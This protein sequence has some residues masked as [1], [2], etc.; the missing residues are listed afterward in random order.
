MTGFEERLR[1]LTP[2]G[3]LSGLPVEA[4]QEAVSA[5]VEAATA[6]DVCDMA[7]AAHSRPPPAWEDGFRKRLADASAQAAPPA[8]RQLAVLAGAALVE[9]FGD[10]SRG[11]LAILCSVGARHAG[12]APALP[13][14]AVTPQQMRE[15][16]AASRQA[17]APR[18]P[19]ITVP[20]SAYAAKMPASGAA[21]TGDALQA[22]LTAFADGVADALGRGHLALV[23]AA[24]K[25]EAALHEQ[26][27]VLR[28]LLSGYSSVAKRPW[29]ELAPGE[30]A[31]AAAL[32]LDGLTR[33][34]LGV[35][36]AAELLAQTVALSA[37]PG[38]TEAALPAGLMGRLSD[39]GPLADLAP[40]L[41]A[42]RGGRAVAG[43]PG[44]FS[45]D[46]YAELRL[47]DAY[48]EM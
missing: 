2:D 6:D 25:R 38:G 23:R 46:L 32:E 16:A 47:V 19:R 13:E 43:D 39:P 30:A 29:N 14:A 42:A 17:P 36:D 27:G 31:A 10:K 4:W 1:T 18:A 26:V 41:A 8:P 22:A 48:R 35:P 3:D 5:A 15:A 9:A 20:S 45:A 11:A 33:F 34:S 44:A 21:V 28:W 40:V 37:G 24:A 7:R 12:M